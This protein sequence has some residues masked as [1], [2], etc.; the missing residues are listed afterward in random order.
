MDN[1]ILLVTG[2]NGQL[3]TEYQLTKP[4]TGW[5]YIFLSRKDLDITNMN[6]LEKLMN[7]FS[8]DAVLNLAAY[9]NV[10]KA[11]KEEIENAFNANALGPKNLAIICNKKNIPLIHIS[12]DYVFDGEKD[13]PYTETDIENPINQYGRT[14]FLGEKWIQEEHDWYYIIRVSWVYSNNAK[15]FYTTMLNLAQE[16]AEVNVV[17][18]QYGSPT[19]TKEICLAIDKVLGDLDKN[20][21]GVYHFSG[22]GRT[23]WKDFTVE[24]YSQIKVDVKVKGIS[25][26]AWKSKLSRPVNSYMSSEKFAKAFGHFPKHWKN[27][28]REI[29]TDRKIVPIKVGDI[30]IAEN[31]ETKYIIVS[32]DWL[33][34]TAMVSPLEDI[35][36]PTEMT[37]NQLSIT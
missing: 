7:D 34:R 37:F 12:T 25:S 27:A 16:R 32:T 21:S 10:E 19:S 2:A 6:T 3:A 15:N 8:F 11:E 30:V 17:N 36:T 5:D 26:K 31:K 9:T 18:D 35:N 33:K 23:T 14:K 20:K 28:L 24:I 22:L 13:S 1:K 29:V 4:I